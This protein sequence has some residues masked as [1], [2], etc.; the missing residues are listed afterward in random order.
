MLSEWSYNRRNDIKN[1]KTAIVYFKL[2]F[3]REMASIIAEESKL[4]F[5]SKL[6]AKY[7]DNFKDYNFCKN[8]YGYLYL[9]MEI[10]MKMIFFYIVAL[11][12]MRFH[13]YP[14]LITYWAKRHTL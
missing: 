9:G 5:V 13:C 1:C 3:T 7:G 11:I 2:F 14:Q 10:L 4:Y 6:K 8:S 12:F